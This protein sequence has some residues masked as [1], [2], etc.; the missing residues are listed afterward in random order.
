MGFAINLRGDLAKLSDAELA[1]RL[2]AAWKSHDEAAAASRVKLRYSRRGPLRHPWAYRFLSVVGL[3]G[4]GFSYYLG[5]SP[6]LRFD[7]V[8]QHLALCEV[9]DLTDEIER[10]TTLKQAVAT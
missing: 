2:E 9:K 7:A 10:R 5:L 3:Q 4:P 1:G 6:F 8:G